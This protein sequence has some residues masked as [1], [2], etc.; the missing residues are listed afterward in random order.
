MKKEYD[1][2]D[3]EELNEMVECLCDD[4]GDGVCGID[5]MV[6]VVCGREFY[7]N[8]GEEELKY[9]KEVLREYCKVKVGFNLENEEMYVV[10]VEGDEEE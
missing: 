9:V 1:L 8:Y 3:N 6:G 10:S 7:G 5:E 2:F 4:E